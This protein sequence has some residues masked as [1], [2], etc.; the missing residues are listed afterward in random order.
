M[1]IIV[2]ILGLICIYSKRRIQREYNIQNEKLTSSFYSIE[3]SKL[4]RLANSLQ[5]DFYPTFKWLGSKRV[6]SNQPKSGVFPRKLQLFDLT[7]VDS[8]Q[9]DLDAL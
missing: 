4:S 2:I 6:D 5:P 1:D 9:P 7:L 3:F 8:N